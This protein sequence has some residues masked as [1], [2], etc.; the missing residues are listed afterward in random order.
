VR[1]DRRRGRATIGGYRGIS[2]VLEGRSDA[3]Y[4]KL[5]RQQG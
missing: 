5:D 1:V 2:G 4:E 3:L